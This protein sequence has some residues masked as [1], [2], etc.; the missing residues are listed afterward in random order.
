MSSAAEESDDDFREDG[1]AGEVGE[2]P[3]PKLGQRPDLEWDS[4][5]VDLVARHFAEDEGEAAYFDAWIDEKCVAVDLEAVARA[6]TEDKDV[7][8]EL[9]YTELHQ[10]FTA[11]YEARLEAFIHS[12]GWTVPDFYAVMKKSEEMSEG[13]GAAS[14]IGQI[15]LQTFNYEIF[16][17]MLKEAAAAKREEERGSGSPHK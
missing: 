17:I 2:K 12:K 5:I 14:M 8:H 7:L 4:D 15:M 3:K 13:F 9:A 16:F 10:E 6:E 1:K 11:M